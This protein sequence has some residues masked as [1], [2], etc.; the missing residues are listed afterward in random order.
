M[1]IADCCGV[2]KHANKPKT[3]SEHDAHYMV[4]KTQ[5]WCYKHNMR[6]T[7]EMS[8][9]D[10]ER[11]MKSAGVRAIQRVQ[12]FNN[13]RWRINNVI[14]LMKENGLESIFLPKRQE[15]IFIKD[16]WL[17]R[18]GV[19]SKYDCAFLDDCVL[20]DKYEEEILNY[21]QG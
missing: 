4:A 7:R 13:R 5:R 17:Y 8:C 10:F 19:N 14:D 3:P 6:C 16:N 11:D 1:Y 2:C 21:V 18:Q 20:F 15:Y 12:S 9:T